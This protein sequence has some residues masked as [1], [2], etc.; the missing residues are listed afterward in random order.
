MN[1]HINSSYQTKY[2]QHD[3][4]TALEYLY[5]NLYRVA[6]QAE[7][8]YQ[9]DQACCLLKIRLFT[10]YWCHAVGDKLSIKPPV[11]GDLAAMIDQLQQTHLLPD[12]LFVMLHKLRKT[13]NRNAHVCVDMNGDVVVESSLAINTL[14]Q[15]MKDMFELANYL[16]CEL[17]GVSQ[18]DQEWQEPESCNLYHHVSEALKGNGV[19]AYTLADHFYNA[20]EK[21]KQ[22]AKEEGV[23]VKKHTLVLQRDLEY[24]LDKAVRLEQPGSML[25]QA[26][27]YA[28]KKLQVKDNVNIEACFKEALKQDQSGEAY[29][30]Y[31]SYLSNIS[32]HEKALE[33]VKIGANKG[34]EDAINYLLFHHYNKRAEN[35][36][37]Y[38]TIIELGCTHNIKFAYFFECLVNLEQSLAKSGSDLHKKKLKTSLISLKSRQIKGAEFLYSMAEFYQ[39]VDT[40]REIDDIR[41]SIIDEY[42]NVLAY[43]DT[44]MLIFNAMVDS[45]KRSH[46]KALLQNYK[47]A[48]N[49][50]H[51][52]SEKGKIFYKAAMAVI[53]G[54]KDGYS[55]KIDDTPIGLLRK[56]VKLDCDDA[57]TYMKLPEAK[58]IMRNNGSIGTKTT[59]INVDRSKQKQKRK[60]AKKAKKR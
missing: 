7:R 22:Q 3:N 25:L 59:K 24:W 55:Y 54:I 10:E 29:Y 23:K 27:S 41:D 4:F 42:V 19:A 9:E 15:C 2:S 17:E 18:F 58:S 32:K 43:V 34:D 38:L 56:A 51:D 46:R 11:R 20:M 35:Q 21:I 50:S 31:A 40:K 33:L 37:D 14:T 57:K 44:G 49:L 60:A 47:E 28:T 52:S 5:P 8:Y 6:K 30:A 36:L 53:G 16:A 39:L 45:D 1:T 48:A 26:R 12:Y 13:A